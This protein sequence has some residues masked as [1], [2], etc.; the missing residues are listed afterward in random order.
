M[1]LR[2]PIVCLLILLSINKLHAQQLHVRGAYLPA[3]PLLLT[4]L[5]TVQGGIEY[6]G[7][8]NRK[9]ISIKYGY[10][11]SRSFLGDLSLNDNNI[12]IGYRYYASKVKEH[13]VFLGFLPFYSF[14]GKTRN[15]YDTNDFPA[16]AYSIAKWNEIGLA[17][18]F[19]KRFKIIG[20]IS[21]ES[22]LGVQLYTKKVRRDSYNV[23]AE[24]IGT[25]HL[26]TLWESYPYFNVL[27]SFDVL[28]LK[29]STN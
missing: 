8:N 24:K 27:L 17:I 10:T 4:Q 18:A 16:T 14:S 3:T 1:N 23:G 5:S 6:I 13:P 2:K 20:P 25:K 26:A 11:E 9:N 19:G 7:K 29:H 12:H 15:A 21:I 22:S 28:R